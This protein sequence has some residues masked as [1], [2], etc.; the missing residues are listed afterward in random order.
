M[1]EAPDIDLMADVGQP[2]I[3]Q[4]D[5]EQMEYLL[6]ELGYRLSQRGVAASIYVV[7][8]GALALSYGRGQMTPD[9]DASASLAAVFEEAQKIADEHGLSLHWLNDNSR[10]Y[11]PARPEW[12]RQE[13]TEAGLTVYVAPSRHLLAMKLVADRI[14]DA[15]DLV[16]LIEECGAEDYSADQLADLMYEAYAGEDELANILSIHHSDPDATRIEAVR[17]SEDALRRAA[18][19]RASEP[20]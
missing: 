20:L 12:A 4:L 18:R 11:L 5:R 9:V 7:G 2:G 14:K 3:I 15:P 17:R 13:P 6:R 10:P 8:G 1:R 16:L 19:Y